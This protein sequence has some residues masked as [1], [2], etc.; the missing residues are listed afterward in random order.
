MVI[1]FVLKLSLHANRASIPVVAC[2]TDAN[3]LSF[4]VYRSYPKA[5]LEANAAEEA[6][7]IDDVNTARLILRVTF[8]SGNDNAAIVA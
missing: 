1:C 3:I 8:G 7:H 5:N 4:I 2:T 6:N